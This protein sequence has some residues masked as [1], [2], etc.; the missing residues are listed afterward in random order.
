MSSRRCVGALDSLGSRSPKYPTQFR[1]RHL[2]S[3][4]LLGVVLVAVIDL[5][6]AQATFNPSKLGEAETL[7]P[8]LPRARQPIVREDA[9]MA[10]HSRAQ[11]VQLLDRQIAERHPMCELILRV[12]S[13][14]RPPVWL[15]AELTHMALVQTAI[16]PGFRRSK[17]RWP[18]GTAGTGGRVLPRAPFNTPG[19][20]SRRRR[21]HLAGPRCHDRRLIVFGQR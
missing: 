3:G 19:G 15:P 4:T 10:R 2:H 18:G 9:L 13:R 16:A 7:Q 12:L 11:A 20:R 6:R 5:P 8:M 17:P 14:N 1:R 21:K